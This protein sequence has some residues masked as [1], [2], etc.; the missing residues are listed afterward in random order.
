LDTGKS[1]TGYHSLYYYDMNDSGTYKYRYEVDPQRNHPP[2]ACGSSQCYTKA[3]WEGHKFPDT[4]IEDWSFAQEALH[5]S[6]LDSTDGDKYLVARAH[7]SSVCYPT[8]LGIHKQFPAVPKN[9]LPTEFY[10]A[11]APKVVAKTKAAVQEKK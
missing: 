2:Y 8:Q 3:W 6:Q 11:I 9:E 1:V 5:N 10:A 4:G 7:V